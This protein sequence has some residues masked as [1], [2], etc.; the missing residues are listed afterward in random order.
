MLDKIPQNR[1]ILYMMILGLFPLLI[2]GVNFMN[3]KKVLDELDQQL[4]H[5]QQL[6]LTRE[7][8]Q[9]TNMAVW[10]HFR[11]ADHYYIDKNLETLTF[12]EPEI[13]VLQNL[14]DN[15]YFAGDETVKKRLDFLTGP[16]NTILF[17]EGNIQSYP[18]FQET[19]DTLSRPVEVNLS[20]MKKLLSLI[21]GVKIGSFEPKEGRPQFIV[22]DFKIDKKEVTDKNEVFV[23]N[24]KMLKREYQ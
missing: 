3:K 7:Q 22:L 21:E 19:T 16:N 10:E 4:L 23:L 24:L 8:K 12:L 17:S 2:V 11:N 13:Q 9:S 20:D 18:F 1:L 14:V 15:K 6:V 5:V